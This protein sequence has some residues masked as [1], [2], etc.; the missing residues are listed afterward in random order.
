[1]GTKSDI[2]LFRER[3]GS[4][5][6]SRVGDGIL[7]VGVLVGAGMLFGMSLGAFGGSSE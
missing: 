2:S 5:T 7:K 1:M 4:G 3:D 6:V